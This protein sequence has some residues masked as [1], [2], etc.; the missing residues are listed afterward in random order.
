[1]SSKSMTV[2][3]PRPTIAVWK[4]SGS[5]KIRT[6]GPETP[7]AGGDAYPSATATINGHRC[8]AYS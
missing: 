4:A 6:R 1:M 5:S 2:G 7:I 8:R 3:A